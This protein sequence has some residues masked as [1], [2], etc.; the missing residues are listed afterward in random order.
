MLTLA[1]TDPQK[2]KFYT[3]HIETFSSFTLLM[4]LIVRLAIGTTVFIVLPTDLTIDITYCTENIVFVVLVIVAIAEEF[5]TL[6][7]KFKY[8]RFFV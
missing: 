3:Q 7:I 1:F 6:V 4:F 8:S 2:E 5:P